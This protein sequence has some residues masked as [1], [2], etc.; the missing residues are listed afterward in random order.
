MGITPATLRHA[1]LGLTVASWAT[2]VWM[3]WFAAP[4]WS[5]Q[6]DVSAP[7][8]RTLLYY[9]PPIAWA[10]FAAYLVV[11]ACSVAY[12]NER[13][14]RYD[15]PARSAAEVG[16]LLNTLALVTGTLWG[17]Q[18]WSKT[19]THALATVFS[20]PKVLAVLILWLTFVAYFLLRRAT[21]GIERQARL[22]AVFGVLGFLGVPLSFATSRVVATS[23]H[24]DVIGPAAN[25][26]A[27][28]SG[29]VSLILAVGAVAFLSLF[30]HLFLQRLRIHRIEETLEDLT[31][32]NHGQ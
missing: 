6:P 27:A 17:I 2:L 32:H 4:D 30:A 31:E 15:A 16:L 25:P 14:L 9:H 23:R 24:P 8:T 22:A 13:D 1:T 28:I 3:T 12:L 5:Y 18:E 26:D 7:L 21:D 10:S 20:E 29:D 11:F 19:G